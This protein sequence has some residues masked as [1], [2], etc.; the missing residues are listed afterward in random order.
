M[1]DIRDRIGDEGQ[2]EWG[3]WG[4][5]RECK[6]LAQPRRNVKSIGPEHRGRGSGELGC[7]ESARRSKS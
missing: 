5:L 6:A 4:G 7:S 2:M 1:N 3:G